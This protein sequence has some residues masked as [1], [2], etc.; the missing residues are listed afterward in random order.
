MAVATAFSTSLETCRDVFAEEEN[1]KM[2]TVR[3]R[4][5]GLFTRVAT[6]TKFL[7]AVMLGPVGRNL[8]VGG[9]ITPR[10]LTCWEL[11]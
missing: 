11:Q 3:K 8:A 5:K 1:T 6:G 7:S 10:T 9:F 4:A 2:K